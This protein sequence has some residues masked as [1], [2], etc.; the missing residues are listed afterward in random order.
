[1]Y[2]ITTY[3]AQGTSQLLL[4]IPDLSD[5]GLF[6][7]ASILV[8]LA[9]VPVALTKVVPPELPEAVQVNLR[10]LYSIS[11]TVIIGAPAAGALLGAVYGWGHHSHS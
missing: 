8:S 4:N 10:E 1:M 3:L 7:L 9:I 6:I 2:Q 5:F 11:P